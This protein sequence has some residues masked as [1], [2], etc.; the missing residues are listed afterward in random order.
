MGLPAARWVGRRK[1]GEIKGNKVSGIQG[2]VLEAY[3][4]AECYSS[5][6]HNAHFKVA[7]REGFM[8]TVLVTK[9]NN[10]LL[11]RACA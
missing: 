10:L 4:T 8:L 6:N 3:C 5:Q 1:W 9:K 7:T 2:D 11:R